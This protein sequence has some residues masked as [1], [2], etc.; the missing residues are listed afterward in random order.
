MGYENRFKGELKVTKNADTPQY[1]EMLVKLAAE[2]KVPLPSLPNGLSEEDIQAINA[3]QMWS[4]YFIVEPE[5]IVADNASDPGNVW[6]VDDS[7]QVMLTVLKNSGCLA[8]GTIYRLGEESGDLTRYTISDN[9]LVTDEAKLVW[10]SDNT[11][12]DYHLYAL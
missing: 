10:E 7:F 4:R 1:P 8:N 3:D 11:A 2:N 6:D 5:S 12:V 9:V